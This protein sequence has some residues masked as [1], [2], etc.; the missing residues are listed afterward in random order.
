MLDSLIFAEAVFLGVKDARAPALAIAAASSLN[1]GG[2]LLLCGH[3]RLGVE[4]AAW[5]TVFSQYGA[6]LVN[7]FLVSVLR[8]DV[9][10]DGSVTPFDAWC[11]VVEKNKDTRLGTWL[12]FNELHLQNPDGPAP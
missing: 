3:W 6:T 12:G 7:K 4:G 11:M 1:L 9:D 8:L 2:D 5:A 10:G